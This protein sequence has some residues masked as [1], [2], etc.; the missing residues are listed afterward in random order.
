MRP[1]SRSMSYGPVEEGNRRRGPAWPWRGCRADHGGEPRGWPRRSRE[2]CGALDL[3]EWSSP[4]SSWN[5]LSAISTASPAVPAM[6][7]AEYSSAGKTVLDVA[8]RARLAVA[9]VA[10]RSPSQD[11]RQPGNDA[12][13]VVVP[14]R[15]PRSAPG[16]AGGAVARQHLG[17]LVDRLGAGDGGR[18]LGGLR[19]DPFAGLVP[20]HR[21]AR[22][23][24]LRG[25]VFGVRV[26]DVEPR[27]VGE[28]DI[29]QA[30]VLVGELAGV[31]GLTG[32]IE[33]SRVTQ[34]VLLLEVPA[35]ASRPVHRR[36]VGVDDL[37]RGE[38]G[39]GVGV[40][41]DGDPV[42]RLDAHYSPYGHAA[43]LAR[44]RPLPERRSRT[45][46]VS[47]A[48]VRCPSPHCATRRYRRA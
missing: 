10:R 23:G 7:T 8:L 48:S 31:G 20:E 47:G 30:D 4:S 2:R 44:R 36:R 32:E 11:R 33:A 16:A 27:A 41:G 13:D 43:L 9:L 1:L 15:A 18:P 45:A 6:P 29:G 5:S 14:C 28:D 3:R 19:H 35:G 21:V 25:A 12:G 22:I 46:A 34:R 39:I 40:T 26:V 37:G 38:H 24:D 42:L 17:R